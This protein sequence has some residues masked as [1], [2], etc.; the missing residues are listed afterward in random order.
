LYWT[1][2]EEKNRK[3]KLNHG[4]SFQ[5]AQYVFTDP[6]AISR[7][8]P[9]PYE[10]RWQTLGLIGQMTVF[11]VHTCAKVDAETGQE[12]GRIISAR[13]AT[14]YERRAYEEETF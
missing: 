8:D 13:Q 1:W 2:D 14:P 3:N 5:S 4:L 10:E 6:L 11:V 9:Y 12:T 7:L